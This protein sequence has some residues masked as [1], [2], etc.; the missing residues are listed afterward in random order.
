M[1]IALPELCERYKRLYVPL[2]CDVLDT[3]GYWYQVMP[4]EIMPLAVDMQVAGVAFTIN[5]YDEHS[6]DK[7]IRKGA[8]AIDYLTPNSVAV[9]QT[10]GNHNTG[11]WGEL[12][13]TG[14]LRQGCN[15]PVIDGGIRDTTRILKL[16]FPVFSRFRCAGDARGR[17]NV[18]EWQT[19]I[20]CGGVRVRPGDFIFG[21]AD[22]VIVVPKEITVEVLVKSEENNAQ[23]DR[24]REQ[25]RQGASLGELYQKVEVF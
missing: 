19:E 1:D 5:G 17:W 14:A 3:L 13:T 11:H 18:V 9:M 8:A 20:N 10:N 22:G 2:V 4:H 16:G 25:I 7:S 12:L 6:T 15:D 23:E 21:D 24:I